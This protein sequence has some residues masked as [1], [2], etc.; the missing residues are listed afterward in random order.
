MKRNKNYGYYQSPIGWIKIF[1]DEQ[2]ISLSF[3]DDISQEQRIPSNNPVINNCINQLNKYFNYKLQEFNL[4][5]AI[6]GTS[7]QEL[8]W[9]ET[10]KI[11]YGVTISYQELAK[12]INRPKAVRAVGT[13]LGKNPLAIIIPCHRVVRSDNNKIVN[14]F[15]GKE[16]KLFLQSL[17]QKKLAINC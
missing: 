4:P 14:Y 10:F 9:S 13:A 12:R 5:L 3:V 6:K 8:V 1:A 16:R 17:E 2:V 11:P 15:W 7:F